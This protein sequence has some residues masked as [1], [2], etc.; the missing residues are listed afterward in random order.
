MSSKVQEGV[1]FFCN[2]AM[3]I[4]RTIYIT[5]WD[6]PGEWSGLK[7]VFLYKVLTDKHSSCSRVQED[8][9]SNTLRDSTRNC[10][11]LGASLRIVVALTFSTFWACGPWQTF[12]M[13]P[14]VCHS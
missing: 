5:Q 4:G 3:F 10:K 11:S 6:G 14:G 2:G 7:L 13:W 8:G 9:V 1:D 12:T